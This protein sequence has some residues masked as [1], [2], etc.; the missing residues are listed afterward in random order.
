MAAGGDVDFALQHCYAGPLVESASM[1]DPDNL[2]TYFSN[3]D[4]LTVVFNVETSMPAVTSKW[5]IHKLLTFCTPCNPGC[6]RSPMGSPYD[7]EYNGLGSAYSGHWADHHTLVI[8]LL[9][10]TLPNAGRCAD[11]R[12]RF[13]DDGSWKVITSYAATRAPMILSLIHI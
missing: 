2:D 7:E 5:E 8:T 9:N 13:A 6:E 10:V 11:D 4:E 1:R 3:G 12:M